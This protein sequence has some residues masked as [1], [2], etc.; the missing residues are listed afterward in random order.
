MGADNWTVCPRCLSIEV[1]K[2]GKAIEKV[3]QSY[4][5]VAPEKFLEMMQTINQPIKQEATLREDYELG[6]S[7]GGFFKISYSAC[8]GICDFRYSYEREEPVLQ[9]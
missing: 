4:G 5:K 8:C 7:R 2:M 6:I 3:N 1:A 9:S